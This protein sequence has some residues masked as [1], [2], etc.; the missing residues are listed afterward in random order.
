MTLLLDRSAL[1]ARRGLAAGSLAPLAD[2]LDRDLRRFVGDRE[3]FVPSE[4]AKLTRHGGRCRDD[5]ALLLFDPGSPRRHVCPSCRREY[6]GDDDYRWWVMGYQLWLAERAVHASVLWALR[7]DD[8]HRGVFGRIATAIADHYLSYPD[9][10]N[11]LGPTRPFFSTYLE[12]IWLLQ[13]C[14]ALD[15][16]ETAGGS[17]PVGGVLRDRVIGPSAA[18]IASYDEGLSNRQTWNDAALGA[19]G[20]LLDRPDLVDAALHGPSGLVAHLSHGLLDDGSWYEGEN[21]HLFAHRGLWYLVAQAACAGVPLPGALVRRF[22]AGF[23]TPFLTALPDFTFPSRRDAPYAVSL[24]QWRI[25]ESCELGLARIPGDGRLAGALAELYR[26][27]APDG[28]PARWRSTAE[29][30]RNVPAARLTRADLGWKSLLFALPERPAT[31]AA[32]P[33]SVLLPGQ[34]FGVLRRSEGAIY[35]ALD[36][37]TTGGGHGHPDRLNLWLVNGLHRVLEDVGTGSYVERTLHWYRSTLAHN[38]PLVDGRSQQRVAGRLRSWE[39]QGDVGWIDA[40]AEVAPGVLVR[41][42]VVVARGYL[43]DDVRWSAGG[44]VMFDL[45]VHVEAVSSASSTWEQAP[46]GGGSDAEDGFAFVDASECAGDAFPL[47]IT[48]DGARAWVCPDPGSE[49]WRCRAPGPP[50]S[51][52]RWFYLARSRRRS[53]RIVSVW[54]WDGA[55]TDAARDGDDVVL[56]LA[57][58]ARHRHRSGDA[59]WTIDVSADGHDRMVQLGGARAVE[60]EGTGEE[61]EQGT[62]GPEEAA[63]GNDAGPSARVP[64]LRRAPES[65]GELTRWTDSMGTG[66]PL[67]YRLGRA[68]YRRSEATWKLAGAP[69]ALVALGAT[70]HALFVEVSVRK[71][72]LAFAPAVAENP[73]DNEH[74]DVNS[75][76]VQLHLAPGRSAPGLSW[77]FV[78]EGDHVRVSPRAGAG[79][80]DDVSAS[81]RRTGTG[82]QLLIRIARRYLGGPGARDFTLDVLVNETSPERERRRGQLVLSGARDEWV[83]LRGDRQDV[84]R[85]LPMHIGDD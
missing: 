47:A 62:S 15:V 6:D 73:L 19:A 61:W 4:K 1:E 41:R 36:Y 39:E 72:T 52:P 75:D 28:D 5:G 24:R 69:E 25:A 42:R 56:M 49:C 9:R 8:W 85:F 54:A 71:P 13:L 84:A 81:W 11:V 12:S 59:G 7:G 60:Q 76:G 74:P 43:V 79:A 30:E 23:A 70:A 10:D 27:D 21:Y 65:V 17:D 66:A 22:D 31:T 16:M 82:Y 55:V 26:D 40:E 32:P 57:G 58:G 80:A 48:A 38:A 2:S 34:G 33:A 45:P 20:V 46:I 64:I 63:R 35:V 3:V 29:A 18:L 37:G 51:A 50:G 68:H 67:Q 53:G 78:P 14:V 44:A 77:I 83:Y